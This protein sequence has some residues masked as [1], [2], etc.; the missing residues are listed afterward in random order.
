[1]KSHYQNELEYLKNEVA[2]LTNLFAQLLRSKNR[3][4][5]FAQPPMKAPAAHIPHTYHN[6]TN[7]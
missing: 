5:T 1:M 3:E 4:G 6:I 7:E 2:R